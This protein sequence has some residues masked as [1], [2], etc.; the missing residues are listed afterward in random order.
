MTTYPW[1]DDTDL[2]VE[3][4]PEDRGK[5]YFEFVPSHMPSH[6]GRLNPPIVYLIRTSRMPIP[7]MRSMEEAA[8]EMPKHLMYGNMHGYQLR[9]VQAVLS[10]IFAPLVMEGELKAPVRRMSQSS[11]DL[12][13]VSEQQRMQLKEEVALELQKF[14]GVLD[15]YVTKT[16]MK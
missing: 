5:H 13:P 7:V 14:L 4:L 15:R 10:K 1:D 6:F 2:D 3:S 8:R 11:L 12:Q 9:P 16:V